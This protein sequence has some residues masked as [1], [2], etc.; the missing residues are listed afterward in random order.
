VRNV[1]EEEASA[2]VGEIVYALAGF[3]RSTV[4]NQVGPTTVHLIVDRAA[5]DRLLDASAKLAQR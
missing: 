3:L 5:W 1:T 4:P 2:G